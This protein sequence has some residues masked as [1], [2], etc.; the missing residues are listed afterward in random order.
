MISPV[1]A[2][3]CGCCVKTLSN[4]A[5][6][7]H[8]VLCMLSCEPISLSCELKGVLMSVYIKSS[9]R[10]GKKETNVG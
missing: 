7:V 3:T 1:D 6:S 8:T 4:N 2:K 5:C 10:L 9:Q